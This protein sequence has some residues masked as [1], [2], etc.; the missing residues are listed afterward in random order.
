MTIRPRV[1]G[2]PVDVLPAD[3]MT[4]RLHTIIRG[5][6]LHDI[7]TLNPEQIMAARRDPQT[8]TLLTAAQI[9]TVDGVG[10]QWALRLQGVADVHRITGVDIVNIVAGL[11][12]PFYLLGGKPGAAERAAECL[13]TNHPDAAITGAWSGGTPDP[14]DDEQTIARIAESGAVAIAVAYGA[15][16]QT[17]WIERNREALQSAGV[18]I[19]VG[20]GGALDFFAGKIRRAPDWMQR[21]GLEWLFRLGVE[22]WRL[23]RQM[24][25]PGFAFLAA[26]EAIRV[27]F[28]R[29]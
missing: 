27:R 24:V 19:A 29:A 3:E 13:R 11:G 2:C 21:T 16:A 25:L 14:R 17:A 5:E 12:F 8:E 6:A 28:G 20:V 23:R 18:R 10:V 4:A 7:V 1:L 22:P 9:C 15:P 26:V